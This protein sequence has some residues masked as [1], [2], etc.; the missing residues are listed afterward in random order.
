MRINK[1][2][3]E[4]VAELSRIKLDESTTEKMIK[5]LGAV[6]EYMGILNRLDTE[7]VEPMSHVFPITNVMRED[8]VIPSYDREE[9]LGNAPARTDETLIVPITIE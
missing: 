5:E 3:V 2:L 4:Y 1:E 8:I 9:I 7:G 6:I